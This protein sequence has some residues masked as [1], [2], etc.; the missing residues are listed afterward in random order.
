MEWR[1]QG[2]VISARRH[3]ESSAIVSIL[4]EQY[5]RHLGVIRTSHKSNAVLQPGTKVKATWKARLPEHLGT[6][7]LEPLAISCAN[8][9]N[10]PAA[11]TALSAACAWIELALPERENHTL[12]YHQF[13]NLL[14]SFTESSWWQTYVCFE[15]HLLRELGFGLELSQCAA[16][17]IN[18][19]LVYVSPRT[20]RAV[21]KEA[22]KPYHDRLLPLPTFLVKHQSIVN[23]ADIRDG[24]KLM[25]YFL[26]RRILS[27]HNSAMPAA[28]LRLSSQL[29]Q[30][31]EFSTL[32][33]CA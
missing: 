18:Q 24:L 2:I 14:Q 29:A 15:L 21:S 10:I 17:G 5:G 16:T 32:D 26:A 33:K 25:E 22:G 11:L 9:L 3:G 23:H 28:R 31:M 13:N 4:T 12:L 30:S 8:I 27:Q 7:T 19:N 1:D 20:G 6:W